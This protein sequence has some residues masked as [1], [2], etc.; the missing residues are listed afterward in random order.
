VQTQFASDVM[1]AISI[2][3]KVATAKLRRNQQSGGAQRVSSSQPTM[4]SSAISSRKAGQRV[5]MVVALLDQLEEA[6]TRPSR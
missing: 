3:S 5:I 4:A 6:D 2:T 1:Q